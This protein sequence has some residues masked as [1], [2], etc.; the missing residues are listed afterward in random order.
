VSTASPMLSLRQQLDEITATIPNEIGSRIGAGVTEI[1]A[2]GVAPGLAIGAHAPNF[3]LPDALGQPVAL[4]DLLAQGP[5]VV[6]FYRGEWCPYCNLQLRGLQQ[7]F[8]ASVNSAR[9]LW[10]SA[11]RSQITASHSPRSTNSPF[12]SSAILIRKPSAATWFSS[13]LPA[14]SRTSR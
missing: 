6:T 5:V 13:R 11:R 2:S 7:H 3:T 12:L 14:I 1:D 8:P 9:R 10:P 4:A